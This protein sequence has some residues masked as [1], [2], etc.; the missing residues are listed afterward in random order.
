M[1][2]I[3]LIVASGKSSRFGGFP[4]AFCRL[5]KGT[6]LDNTIRKAKGYFDRVF[7]GVNKTTYSAFCN[8]VNA[9]EM[10]AIKT[11]QGDAHSML[12]CIEYVKGKVPGIKRIVVCWG[13]AV[14]SNSIPFQQFLERS[15]DMD[16]AV[17]CAMDDN[18]YA[19]FDIDENNQIL[20]AHFAK[21]EGTIE[22]GMHDQSL[23]SFNTEFVCK[24]LNEY[25]ELLGIRYDND[26]S[27]AD[28]NE[29]KLLFSFEYLL[30]NNMPAKCIQIDAGNI[31]SFNTQEELENIK[32]LINL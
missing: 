2:N 28:V 27:N 26:E 4:K 10:F 32:K 19:W 7:I 29:M 6:N 25:R 23:F 8:S 11:G 5:R 22:S 15:K 21:E 24:Y 18:P 3:L 1:E 9:C 20:K 12:K 30:N 16:V 17:A 14:F 13:D 31:L